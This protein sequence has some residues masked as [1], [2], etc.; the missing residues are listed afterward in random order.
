MLNRM[1]KQAGTSTSAYADRYRAEQDLICKDELSA[2]LNFNSVLA[3]F[4]A[5]LEEQ[6]QPN[7]SL[8]VADS[9]VL[10]QVQVK[11]IKTAAVIF[12]TVLHL[13][14]MTVTSDSGFLAG[15]SFCSARFQSK[16]HM[17]PTIFKCRS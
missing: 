16:A 11:C 15:F 4:E 1:T 17:K 13:D 2:E 3:E 9:T 6:R 7:M 14:Y 8:L 12:C 5:L 10:L